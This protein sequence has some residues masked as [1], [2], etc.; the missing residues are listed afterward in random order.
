MNNYS[1]RWSAE[2]QVAFSGEYRFVI[3]VNN[4]GRLWLDGRLLIDRWPNDGTIPEYTTKGIQLVAGNV[5]SLVMEWN[6]F[7]AG[8]LARLEWIDP[9]GDRTVIP[10]GALQLPL[11]ANRPNPAHG[12]TD[13][14]DAAILRWSPGDKAARHDVYFGESAEA[15]AAADTTSGLYQG[16]QALDETSFDPGVLEW[17]K[18]YFWRID[19]VNDA[20]ADSPWKGPVWSFTTADFLV[21]DD[22]E[23][24][25]DDE[26]SRIYETWID[27]YTTTLN[28]SVIGYL[29]APFAEQTIVH[30]GRQ[31]MPMDYNNVIA[32]YYSE[33]ER[34][35]DKPQ[36]WTVNGVDTLTL[37]VRGRTANGAGGLYVALEDSAGKL[38]VVAHSDPAIL[39]AAKWNEWKIPLSRFTTAGVNVTRITK[40]Y[41]GVGDR[42]APAPG[43]AG[44]FFLD[45]IRVT[46]SQ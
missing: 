10:A 31:S 23:A 11:R 12:Q 9:F 8:S 13:V 41:I 39:A 17:G 29:Q 2:L 26:G 20:S 19:E 38:A 21:I 1:A 30:T 32:P 22:F 15:V 40:M 43:G 14:I 4:S 5:Y 18:T 16:R 24:Y 7:N 27:G 44:R 6:K 25:T 33:G 28:N 42:N 35:W 34:T 36:N 37:Y 3:N 46:K 45:N